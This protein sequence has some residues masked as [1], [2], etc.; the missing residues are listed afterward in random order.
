MS[1]LISLDSIAQH[2]PD[3]V[4]GKAYALG[5]LL[6]AGRKVPMGLC[7]TTQ[8]YDAYVRSAGLFERIAMELGRKDFSEM[9]WEEMWDVSLRI[10]NM[11][12]NTPM[13]I[14]LLEQL[15]GR[16][17]ETF[18]NRPVAVRSSAP[19]EDS[20]KVTFAG[21][22]ETYM[23]VCGVYSILEHIRLVW[24]SLWADGALLYRQEMGLDT[25]T[26][27]MAV[28]IQEF[29]NGETSGV[30]FGMNPNEDEQV[31]IE[32]VYGLNQ[33]LVDGTVEPDRWILDRPSG[34][35]L[36]HMAVKREQ[37]VVPSSTGTQV[38]GLSPQQHNT[39]PLTDDEV[40]Q[41]Y[42][43][44]M[45][46]QEVFGCPQDV[47]WTFHQ[48]ELFL[49]Q[50]RAVT[51]P[52]QEGSTDNR[53]WYL[54]LR[55]SFGN[56]KNLKE[57]IEGELV[58]EMKQVAE[59]LSGIDMTVIGDDELGDELLKRSGIYHSWEKRYWRYFIPFAHGMRLF[60]QVYNDTVR[61][62][63]PFEF[64]D[65]LV[66]SDL[67]SIKR[68]NMLERMASLVRKENRLRDALR[69]D[70]DTSWSVEFSRLIDEFIETFGDLSCGA[71]EC[72]YDRDSIKSVV[73]E[74]AVRPPAKSFKDTY[75]IEKLT[76]DFLSLFSGDKRSFAAEILDIARASYRLRDD[77]N[78]YLGRI[79]QR[80][81][82]VQDEARKRLERRGVSVQGYVTAQ[83]LAHAL[84]NPEYVMQ[85]IAEPEEPEG[86]EH[87]VLK[88]RQLTGQPASRGIVSG[89]ARVIKTGDDLLGFKA[90]EVLVC[91]A[92]DPDMT[93]IVPL[94]I[95]IVERRGGMLIHG[96]I[97]ARE[98]GLPCVTGVPDATELIQTGKQITVDGYLG[99]VIIA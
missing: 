54:T 34:K 6:T 44:V 92:L 37:R 10:R 27:S 67:L 36:S 89:I 61:P 68:N 35:I 60:G 42:D 20:L 22:H 91:D 13:P 12:L 1:L 74:M 30:V 26:S 52:N 32:S 65:L 48:G 56:L 78:I 18:G 94:A 73:R 85:S 86:A 15:K 72:S 79:R 8:A 51:T 25:E 70:E 90:G 83:D 81:I 38:E 80:L 62:L 69:H 7:V 75:D 19:G 14:S 64:M 98:Y 97:I 28:L 95:G 33:G 84:K 39:P 3:L 63:D 57:K 24:A 49:L 17:E 58:P 93:F 59:V 4:G 66:I 76:E 29:I 11:F 82:T 96:A 71:A 23:N 5:I 40:R 45:Q 31:V 99:I 53:S 77:D 87:I 2:D 9:R 41:V 16:I 47:E 43:L 46:A 55:R 88:A 21:I 50:S